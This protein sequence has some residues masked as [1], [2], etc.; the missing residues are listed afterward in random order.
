MAHRTPGDLVQYRLTGSDIP[1]WPA[2]ICTDDFATPEDLRN[3]PSGYVT[4][5]LVLGEDPVV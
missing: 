2:V 5:V 1:P 4:L 3:R